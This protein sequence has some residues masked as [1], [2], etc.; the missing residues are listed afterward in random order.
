VSIHDKHF[1][2]IIRKM[3]AKV[4]V[5]RP[6]DTDLLAGSLVDRSRFAEISDQATSQGNEPASAKPV[7][8]GI[9]KA[10]LNTDSFLSA[11]SFQHTIKVLSRAAIEGQR[12]ELKGLKEN[13]IIGRLIP[14]GTGFWTH[15]QDEM[16]QLVEAKKE[17]EASLEAELD[18]DG[19][20]ALED[21]DPNTGEVDLQLTEQILV[22]V[23][24][25]KG[26]GPN[27]EHQN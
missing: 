4:Q 23:P 21:I 17:V 9:T 25:Q 26:S 3:L 11:S 19:S 13:V 7:L 6:G 14:A 12:D 16:A 1:E 22:M 8:L 5:L 27:Q 2:V 10:A 24:E 15:H 20:L 18:L